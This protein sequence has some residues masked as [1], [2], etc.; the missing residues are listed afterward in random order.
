MPAKWLQRPRLPPILET[1]DDMF[2]T[3]GIPWED[4]ASE[5]QSSKSKKYH[6]RPLLHQKVGVHGRLPDAAVRAA[7]VPKFAI[8]RL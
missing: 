7:R 8:V 4:P 2:G 3:E 6:L 1:S 5:L